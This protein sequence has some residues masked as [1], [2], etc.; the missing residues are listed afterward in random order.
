MEL[1]IDGTF[2]GQRLR[3]AADLKFIDDP[4]KDRIELFKA[5]SMSLASEIKG[6]NGCVER[7]WFCL[8][9]SSWRKKFEQA[10]PV[11]SIKSSEEQVYKANRDFDKDY[12][13]VKYYAAFE[14]W[15][16]MLSSKLGIP[17][18][19][20]K[21][22]EADDLVYVITKAFSSKKIMSIG[23]SSDGDYYQ[24]V[25]EHVFLV[26]LPTKDLY[27]AISKEV[28]EVKD[29]MS[30]FGARP[31]KSKLLLDAFDKKHIKEINPMKSMFF[32]VV[33]GDGKDNV[34]PLFF[35]IKNNKTYKPAAGHITKALKKLDIVYD[36]ISEA[37]IYDKDLMQKF[38]TEILKI[39]KQSRDEEH[40]Y[41]VFESNLK[42]KHLSVKQI[43]KEVMT[44]TIKVINANISCKQDIKKM[45]DYKW[46]LSQMGQK[47]ENSMFA[48][49]NLE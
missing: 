23:W 2:F 15:Y 47:E 12:D 13:T 10:F 20:I 24:I 16:T 41:K 42:M 6:L 18:I 26:K 17:V 5:A 45:H 40:T 31:N 35:W 22:A 9:Y 34:P 3:N 46:I 44:E 4:K 32:K 19:K 30:V 1:V 28:N 36:N 29:M 33:H 7:I 8:D 11:E 25:N 48:K 14:E 43:P 27:K 49:F 39:C 37:N 21:G 38:I